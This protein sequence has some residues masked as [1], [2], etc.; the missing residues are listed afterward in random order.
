MDQ[1]LFICT[2]ITTHELQCRQLQNECVLI[3]MQ[4]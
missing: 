1:L 3:S 4:K 2:F